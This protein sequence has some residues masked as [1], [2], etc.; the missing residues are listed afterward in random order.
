MKPAHKSLTVGG[1]LLAAFGVLA[2]PTIYALLPH[3][4]AVTVAVIGVVLN[5]FG[6]RRAVAKLSPKP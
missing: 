5:Q 4:A 3:K 1:A 2:D 6:L